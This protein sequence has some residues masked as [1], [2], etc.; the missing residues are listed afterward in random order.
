MVAGFNPSVKHGDTEFTTIKDM[1]GAQLGD[2]SKFV[3][4]GKQPAG[5]V[6]TKDSGEQYMLGG[7]IENGKITLTHKDDGTITEFKEPIIVSLDRNNK[8][9]KESAEL[10]SKQKPEEIVMADKNPTAQEIL[11]QETVDATARAK[12]QVRMGSFKEL[13]DKGVV[14]SPDGGSAEYNTASIQAHCS[15][16]AVKSG[17]CI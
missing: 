12:E 2:L 4:E 14:M 6:I 11:R 16:K 3:P 8:V 9:T 10:L 15:A 5:V 7:Y 1:A 17:H 13:S